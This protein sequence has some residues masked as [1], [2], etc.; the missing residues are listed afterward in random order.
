MAL[1][2]VKRD[3][4]AERQVLVG[5]LVS[6][7]VL[8]PIAARW[9]EAGLF[10]SKWANLV[11]SWA[12]SH[13]RRYDGKAPGQAIEHYYKTW[14]ATGDTETADLVEG[15]LVGLS[16]EAERL[17]SRLSPDHLLDVA[18]DLFER[19]HIKRLIEQADAYLETGQPAKARELLSRSRKVEI[20]LG[21]G[22]N[23]LT[24]DAAFQSALE[25]LP[26]SLISYPDALGN[27]FGK[28]LYR[29][30]FVAFMGKAKIGKSYLLQDLAWQAV[31]QGR[32][33]AYFELGDSSQP[34]VLQRF[35]ARMCGRPLDL[36]RYSVPTWMETSGTRE[37]PQLRCDRRETHH[38]L[39][40][41][42]ERATRRRWA[43]RVGAD[44]FKLSCHPSGSV[45]VAGVETILE[46]WE[47]DDWRPDIIICD[48]V[49]IM[50]AT[51]AK[52]EKRDQVNQTWIGL[53][54]LSQKRRCLVVTAT[55]IKA[56]G[57]DAWILDRSH[58]SEDNRKY[59][60]VTGMVGINQTKQEKEAGVYRLNWLLGRQ[61]TFSENKCVWTAGCL[62][63]GS[64]FCLSQFGEER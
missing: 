22:I 16:D 5:M 61:L 2:V 8:G 57:F 11:G 24:D 4:S 14:A 18:N 49:D 60:H 13:Y 46:V 9:P 20:G 27:F 43:E 12:V 37:P 41:V 31:E 39:T 59:N 54:S 58:F 62:A 36:Q 7:V 53:R 42:E 38:A 3:S 17:K 52:M 64:P 1:N 33:V 32:N 28:S 29:G 56:E 45:G 19:V 35:A 34:D 47:R 51:D 21:A 55:Q 63:I 48:Y 44:R 6:R 30:A 15:L 25:D 10:A 40:V 23:V 50:A 26:E